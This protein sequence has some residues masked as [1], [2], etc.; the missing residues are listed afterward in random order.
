MSFKVS[1][2]ASL[3]HADILLFPVKNTELHMLV[4][5]AVMQSIMY[6]LPLPLAHHAKR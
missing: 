5:I 2:L 3:T 1:N 6:S 4:L